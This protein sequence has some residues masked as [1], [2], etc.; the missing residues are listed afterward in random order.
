MTEQPERTH[1][2][3]REGLESLKAELKHKVTVERPA[4]AER[5]R[6]AIQQGDLSENA[7]YIDAKEEQSFL[8]GRIQQLEEM[9]RGAVIIEGAASSDGVGL[10]SRVTVVQEG[11][12]PETYI[13][14]GPAEADP[15]AGKISNE[16][17][18]GR[19]LMGHKTGDVV[20]V[21]APAGAL[22]FRIVDIG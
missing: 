17:P 19:A 8:E 3:T 22:T 4:L 21:H 5:L 20:R 15:S 13:V 10:G 9:I 7:D 14:V 12:P 2:M 16:S 1:P 18:L 11:L 6:A